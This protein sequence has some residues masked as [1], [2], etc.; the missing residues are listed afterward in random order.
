M[1]FADACMHPY[2]HGDSSVRRLAHEAAAR[3][4]DGIVCVG[5][6]PPPD[7]PVRVIP[8]AV[9]AGKTFKDISVQVRRESRSADLILACAGDAGLNRALLSYRGIHILKGVHA[10]P[11]RAFDHIC[12][13]NAADSE[14]AVD[15][16]L[17][18]LIG[19]RGAARQKVLQCYADILRLQRRYGFRLAISS[20]ARSVLDLRHVRVI[21]HLCGLFGMEPAETTA[22]LGTVGR[23]LHPDMPVEVLE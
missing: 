3:G 1:N 18:P 13:R 19:S 21:P 10:A 7:T 20:D 2:P 4:Y 23:L 16:S 8:A 14:I 5:I 22:A 15:I 11:R 9:V 6:S 12:A 17:Q